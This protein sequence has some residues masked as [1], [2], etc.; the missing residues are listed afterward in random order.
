MLNFQHKL[1]D[2]FIFTSLNVFQLTDVIFN[3]AE[4][5]YW[6]KQLIHTGEVV[7]FFS[8]PPGIAEIITTK[9]RRNV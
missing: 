8:A 3:I 2:L 5:F 4:Y 9:Q 7:S 6:K 1:A